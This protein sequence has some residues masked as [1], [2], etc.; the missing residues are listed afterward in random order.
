MRPERRNRQR[1]FVIINRRYLE[2][3]LAR[4]LDAL[5]THSTPEQV[6]VFGS[7]ASGHVTE[8]SDLDLM[9]V[10]ETDRRFFDRIRDVVKICDCDIG[11][12]FL[13]T[14]RRNSLKLQVTLFAMK[15]CPKAES[16]IVQQRE[17]WFARAEEDLA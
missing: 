14:H 15:F 3:N 16:Y 12:D 2:E 5:R 11:V 9:I 4:I 6:L 7:L 17:Q 1:Q 13:F 10:K 8:T